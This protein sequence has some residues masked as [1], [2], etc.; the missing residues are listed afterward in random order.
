MKITPEAALRRQEITRRIIY[1]LVALA[2]ITPF[3]HALPFKFKPMTL[4]KNLYDK[5]ESLKPGTPV[6]LALD[7]DPSSMAELQ[8]MSIAILRQCFRR[9]LRVIVMTHWN[10]GVGLC[11]DVCEKMAAEAG[12]ESGKD[13]VFLGFKPGY[14]NLVLNMGENLL[15]AFDK[16]FYQKPTE[17]MPVL[18]GVRSLKDIPLVI[19]IAAGASI[20]G[21]WIPY[22]RDRFGFDLGAGCTAVMAPDLYPYLQSNQL[23]GLLGGLR[24][25]ADYETLIGKPEAATKGMQA[26]SLTHVLLI[27]LLIGA[28]IVYIGRRYFG[29]K[30]A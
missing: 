13:Y 7:Y 29:P 4:S 11:K 1:A 8:P 17:G 3:I 20:D 25:A 19:N 28:N 5:V 15:G 26:Q 9:N 30:E 14:Q 22:G 24:G 16:D 27:V 12:K 18:E 21:L 2:V 10:T 23:I 6:L